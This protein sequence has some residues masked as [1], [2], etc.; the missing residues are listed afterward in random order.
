MH[1]VPSAHDLV[2][3]RF[4]FMFIIQFFTGILETVQLCMYVLVDIILWP[5]IAEYNGV[6]I[7]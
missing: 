5:I 1:A 7:H 6:Y 3:E 2:H 4:V